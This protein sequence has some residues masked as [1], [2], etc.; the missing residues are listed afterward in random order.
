M[1][2]LAVSYSTELSRFG[3]ETTIMVP[4]AFM[5]EVS[6]V[7]LLSPTLC[8]A[9]AVTPCYLLHCSTKGA[10]EQMAKILSKDLA[11]KDI[12]VNAV[13]PGP[14]VTELVMKGKSEELLKTVAGFQSAR[15]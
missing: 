9:S 7:V 11:R 14:T 8:A 1:D 10:I 6:H 13:A 3:I 15:E 4:G 5:K 12:F 2:S